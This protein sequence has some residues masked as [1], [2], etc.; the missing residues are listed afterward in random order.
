MFD[1]KS[2]N[3]RGLLAVLLLAPACSPAD[4]PSDDDVGAQD[5]EDSL[6]DASELD[7]ASDANDTTGESDTG[8]ADSN[9]SCSYASPFTGGSECR[10][11]VGSGWTEAD[12]SADCSMVAGALALGEACS[13]S[14]VLGRCVVDGGTDFEVHYVIYGSDA[15]SCSA[16]QFGCETFA[17]GQWQPDPI[18]EG[19][20]GDGDGDG[21]G[22]V[23]IQPTLN[24]VDP[25]EGEPPGQSEGGKVCTWQSIAASTE[26]GR[27]FADY[28][29]CDI[30]YTQRPYYGAPPKP[31][32]AEPDPRLQDPEYVAELDWVRS[33]IEASGCVCCHSEAIV[34]QGTS[35]W[36]IE[37][38]NN[39]MNS[40][41][42]SGLA[43]GANWIDS[44]SFG[45]FDPADNNGFDRIHSGIPSTD[46][47][48]MV[49]F[50]RDEL[51]WRG[52]SEADFADAAPFGGPLYSQMVY[53]PD[54]CQNGEGV[55]SDGTLVWTGGLARYVYVLAAGTQSPTV[56]PNL[57]LP[58]G[59]LWRVDVPSD[60]DP[61]AS[62]ELVYGQTP[63]G[64]GQ[65]YPAQGNPVALQP[66]EQYYL[67]VTKDV[68]IP[69][70]RCLFTYE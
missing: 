2:L 19:A 10:D 1:S 24:C 12:V 6:D 8:T 70:T 7:D 69:I 35:N 11:Y 30:L 42:D 58:I 18:C 55:A 29:S 39:W 5:T 60:G 47:D 41:Y 66:G 32:P 38:P 34:P 21:G 4:L 25:I 54:A 59:T 37:A 61:I 45:A 52:K 17:G 26:E 28:A 49:Q 9:H 31:A 68:G 33:Q 57:D 67:Y 63:A 43:L 48:R 56:P 62:G 40:F 23:F 13:D 20:G 22:N 51:A 15:D 50:F 14:D 16:Q 53:E 36:Y 64:M 46:P 65:R 27:H 44:T 3:H